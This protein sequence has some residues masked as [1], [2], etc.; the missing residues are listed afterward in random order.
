VILSTVHYYFHFY[1][2]FRS[3]S[4]SFSAH[5]VQFSVEFTTLLLKLY[6]RL[7]SVQFVDDKFYM[8]KLEG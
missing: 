8:L 1:F 4:F 2:S 5:K 6:R 3:L 7:K